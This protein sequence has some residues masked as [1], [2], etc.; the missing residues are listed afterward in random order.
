MPWAPTG[1]TD[2]RALL[3]LLAVS[4]AAAGNLTYGPN[5][6]S[7]SPSFINGQVT[8]NYTPVGISSVTVVAVNDSTNVATF[9]GGCF[10]NGAMA[11]V[12]GSS[13]TV[14]LAGTQRVR[15][16]MSGE[17]TNTTASALNKLNV[18]QNGSF[19]APF[20]ASIPFASSEVTLTGA[21]DPETIHK[22]WVFNPGAGTWTYCLEGATSAGALSFPNATFQ[23]SAEIVQ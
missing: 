16:K 1:G 3:L 9:T 13:V 21:S 11:G 17:I 22:E 15:I 8:F 7:I 18:L 6:S 19:P 23:F 2:V 12:A 20:T 14:T 4:P 5:P 10:L